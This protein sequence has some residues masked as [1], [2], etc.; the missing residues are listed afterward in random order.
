MVGA[1]AAVTLFGLRKLV[2]GPLVTVSWAGLGFLLLAFGFAIK[3]RPYRM[4]GL[5]AVGF[6]L[7]RAVLHDM[8]RVGTVYR[9]LSFI[10]LGVILLVLAFLYARNREKLAK[11]L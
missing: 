6:S 7:L 3:E 11:W 2:S 10:G 5:T 8:A 9:I 4:A 1:V